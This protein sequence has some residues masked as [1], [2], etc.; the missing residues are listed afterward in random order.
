MCRLLHVFDLKMT[1]RSYDYQHQN[2]ICSGSESWP[3]VG[4]GER[5]KSF[6]KRFQKFFDPNLR[7]SFFFNFHFPTKIS[8]D[9]LV[10]SSLERRL[11]FICFSAVTVPRKLS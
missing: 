11:H 9:L 4:G 7:N 6:C 1:L 10:I 8:D 5:Q 2:R 3:W